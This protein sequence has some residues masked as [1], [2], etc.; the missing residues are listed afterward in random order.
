MTQ[1]EIAKRIDRALRAYPEHGLREEMQILRDELD[2]PY[3]EPGKSV[4]WRERG[5]A[6]ADVWDVGVV[7]VHADCVY[8]RYGRVELRGIEWKPARILADD[9]VAVKVPPVLDWPG[10]QSI[11]AVFETD[12]VGT[13]YYDTI[14]TRAEAEARE[15]GR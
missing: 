3:P 4:R 10:G 8:T 7:S 6:Y 2:P 1:K 13:I 9:E 5:G 11:D 15:A 14:I 12:M